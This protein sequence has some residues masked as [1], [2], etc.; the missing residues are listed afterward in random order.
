MIRWQRTPPYGRYCDPMRLDPAQEREWQCLRAV[1]FRV[2]G[3]AFQVR[4]LGSGS[5]FGVQGS[6][7]QRFGI[8]M[9]PEVRNHRGQL[10]AIEQKN[11]EPGT[12]HTAPEHRTRTRNQE[13]GTWNRVMRR[14]HHLHVAS[15]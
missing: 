7:F 4:V 10:D 5:V 11:R 8:F 12:Q 6:W 15:A 1:P 13:H 14:L 9:V 3:S 2:P